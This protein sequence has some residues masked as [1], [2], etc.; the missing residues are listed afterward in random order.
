MRR[1]NLQAEVAIRDTRTVED[2]FGMGTVWT[3]RRIGWPAFVEF[4]KKSALENPKLQRIARS[5]IAGALSDFGPKELA[6]A[7]YKEAME[8][9][10]DLE[11]LLKVAQRSQ[12]VA[13]HLVEKIEGMTDDKNEVVEY[14]AELVEKE[15][16]GDTTPLPPWPQTCTKCEN[17]SNHPDVDAAVCD[18]EEP[19]L[20]DW[21]IDPESP[22]P[23]LRAPGFKDYAGLFYGVAWRT[24][25]Q[26][27]SAED[28]AF[29]DR[30]IEASRKN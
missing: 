11:E 26:E 2:P 16:F 30:F 15:I 27:K 19:E 24:W 25:V 1:L 13:M 29:R 7:V 10:L 17:Y 28:E 5:R 18:C 4:Q 23:Y 21:P 22:S 6:D 14:S 12:G 9:E 20:E 3:I 8:T